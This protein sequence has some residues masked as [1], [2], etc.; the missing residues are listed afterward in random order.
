MPERFDELDVERLRSLFGELDAEL[1]GRAEMRS[2]VRNGRYGPRRAVSWRS[3]ARCW[4]RYSAA[5]GYLPRARSNS[6][7]AAS[8]WPV[9]VSWVEGAFGRAG[10]LAHGWQH[11]TAPAVLTTQRAGRSRDPACG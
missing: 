4:S 1:A 8:G 10:A 3:M 5:P 7:S 11:R 2:G 9:M 6:L